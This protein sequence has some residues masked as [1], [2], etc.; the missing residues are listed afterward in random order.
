METPAGSGVHLVVA[1]DGQVVVHAATDWQQIHIPDRFFR[2]DDSIG[3]GRQ[4]R[5][6][7]RLQGAIAD[8]Y[9]AGA[10]APPQRWQDPLKCTDRPSGCGSPVDFCILR[11]L[12]HSSSH[13]SATAP[14]D[15]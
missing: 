5:K 2:T 3:G 4:L 10:T 1:I 13:M 11:F 12:R 7:G 15:L 8:S 9:Q 6:C 14:S